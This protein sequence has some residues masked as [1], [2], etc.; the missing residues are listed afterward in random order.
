[1]AGDKNCNFSLCKRS[2]I[3]TFHKVVHDVSS[4]LK[5]K[6]Q[7]EPFSLRSTDW[8]STLHIRWERHQGVKVWRNFAKA[9]AYPSNF[10]GFKNHEKY[11]LILLFFKFFFA[12]DQ[13]DDCVTL[14][15]AWS[16]P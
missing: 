16:A 6:K 9:Q 5:Q 10:G 8:K 11:D 4:F 3:G 1:M 15:T 7:N 13:E 12:A 14:T 2:R